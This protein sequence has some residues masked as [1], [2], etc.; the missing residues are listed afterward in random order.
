[1]RGGADAIDVFHWN[2]RNTARIFSHV[3]GV[4][5][6]H[7]IGGEFSQVG[8]GVFGGVSTFNDS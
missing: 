6:Q 4:D 5:E 8:C 1:V 7:Q 2:E 3:G